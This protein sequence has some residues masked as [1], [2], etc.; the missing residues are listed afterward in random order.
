M[1]YPSP[2]RKRALVFFVFCFFSITNF[3]SQSTSLLSRYNSADIK[4]ALKKLNTV[5]TVL[6]IA[7]HP[8]DEN[9]RLLSYF[10]NEKNL[11]TCYLALNRGDGGQNLIGK[12]Q[13]DLLG[14]IRTNELM[15]AR[16]IDG[17]EQYFTRAFDFG[18]SKNSEE[19][20]R[21]WNH[22]SVLSDV[23]W[24]IRK[25]KPDVI[26]TRFPTTGEGG[27]GHHTA[28]A[29]LAGEAFVAAADPTKFSDQL[30]YVDVWQAKSLWWNTFKF[31]DSNTQSESQYKF[32]AGIYNP[33]LGKNYGELAAESRSC[34]KSQ[35]FGVPL[36]RGKQ[37]EY[38]K[39]IAGDTA[40]GNI[41]CN[42]DF[43]YDRILESAKMKALCA[44]AR[45]DFN[46]ENPSAILPILIDIYHEAQ[47]LNDKNW[48]EQK[49]MET[50]KLILA[51]AG[52][53]FEATASDYSVVPGD[54]A[55]CKIS[56]INY[57]NTDVTLTHIRIRD[58]DTTLN[59]KLEQNN[60]I[61][62]EK[63]FL[64]VPNKPYTSPYWLMRHHTDMGYVV[65][66][67]TNIGKPVNDAVYSFKIMLSIL[68][69]P[70]TFNCP[71]QYK[72]NDPV[73]GEKYR[74]FEIVPP[75]TVNFE[76]KV[77]MFVNN[78]TKTIK[79][80]V[81]AFKDSLQA[82]LK[83]NVPDGFVASPSEISVTIDKKNEE[84]TFA[85][86]LSPA[87]IPCPTN[88]TPAIT[89]SV[90]V[91]GIQI[92]K[93]FTELKYN[94]IPYQFVLKDSQIKFVPLNIQTKSKNIGYIE[95]A[96]D[97]IPQ[98]LQQLGCSVTTLTNDMLANE[99]LSK[100]DAIISGVRAFNTNEQLANFHQKFMDYIK[101]GGNMIVQYNTNN[102]LSKINGD[103]GPYP[104]SISR[105]RV[106]DETAAINFDL[107]QHPVLNIPNKITQQDFDYW[108]QERGIYFAKDWDKN[109]QTPFSCNDPN[110][111]PLQG[112][113]LITQY[114]K[115]YFVYTGLVFFRELPAGIPGAWRLFA[116][117]I[118]LGK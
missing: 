81:H 117:M 44:K 71:V 7:A 91:N 116:N 98:C 15:Q 74:A 82:V 89:A 51:C 68:N 77:C 24:L 100:Y 28:S 33:L 59:K 35:G 65:K 18:Y 69:N 61:A 93:S 39:P 1:F 58:D 36:A 107:P 13:G 62:V 20:F 19:T 8:D 80:K 67:K 41:F 79:L 10:A 86:S 4:L 48:R 31:G 2:I 78:Q 42:L 9:T 16:K 34:H 76:D 84:K 25:I 56:I 50:E 83:L 11:R 49:L 110:E 52:I 115:G 40:C 27:H 95:G 103:I 60:L 6:Y 64:V 111:K 14:L 99:D 12:E 37:L 21:I 54:S 102:F 22:D 75:A 3:Y 66:D 63:S 30:Q 32:D 90:T 87:P 106:T 94:H 38:F 23:V 46:S 57:G 88:F 113:T 112:S 85:F 114:G 53:W 118:S 47:K 92:F 73:E 5:G 101:N 55:K 43:S 109:Y 96:G 108:I 72:W 26:I 70:F 29:I 104:F 17:A 105:D 45:D 97:E